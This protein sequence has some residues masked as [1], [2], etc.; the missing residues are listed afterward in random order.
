MKEILCSLV[1]GAVGWWE[2][3]VINDDWKNPEMKTVLKP[4]HFDQIQMVSGQNT[5]LK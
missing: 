2:K 3:Q 1:Q 5:K 4:S